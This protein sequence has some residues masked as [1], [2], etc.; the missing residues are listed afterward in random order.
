MSCVDAK[1]RGVGKHKS[2]QKSTGYPSSLSLSKWCNATLPEI[3][4][5]INKDFLI[6]D[7]IPDKFKNNEELLLIILKILDSDVFGDMYAETL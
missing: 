2:H 1:S 6:Y 5:C 3:I 4:E 7:L